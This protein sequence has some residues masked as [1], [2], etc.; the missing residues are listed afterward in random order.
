M[1]RFFSAVVALLLAVPVAAQEPTVQ[2]ETRGTS[3]TITQNG[4]AVTLT[5]TGGLASLLIQTSGTFDTTWELQCAAD[6]AGTAFDADDEIPVTLVAASPTPAD[7]VTN[8]AEALYTANIAG[9][10]AVRVIATAYSSGT[11]TVTLQAITSGGGSGGGGGGGG[12]AVTGTGSAGTPATGVLTVQGITSGTAVNVS[13]SAGCSSSA[14][15]VVSSSNNSTSNLAG[16]AAFTGTGEEVT[17][18]AQIQVSV[19][20]SHASAANGLSVQQSSDNSNWDI[21]DTFTVSA[22]TAMV[23]SVPAQARYFRVVYTNGATLT[24]SLRIQTIFKAAGAKGS[25]QRPADAMTNE[26][27]FEQGLSYNMGFNGT[28]WD[29]LRTVNTGYL[30]V[31]PHYAGTAASTGTGASGAQTQRVVTATDSTIGTVTSV[32]NVATIGTSVTP[33]NAAA[34]LGKAEDAVAAS[35]DTGVQLLGVRADTA[36]AT[37]ANGDYVPILMDSIGRQWITGADVE[38]AA[39]TAGGSLLMIGCVRQDTAAS[40]SGTSGDNSNCTTDADGRIYANVFGVT[41]A[42]ATYLTVRLS[43]GSNFLTPSTDSTHDSA[44]GTTGPA[45]MG[46]ATTAM[47][48]DTAVADGDATRLKAD[49]NGRQLSLASCPRQDRVRGQATITDGSSTSVLAALGANIIAEIYEIEIANSSAS[50]VTVDMR[51]GTGGSVLWTLIAPATGGNNRT[52]TVPLTFT[53][54][55]AV[56]ADPSASASSIIVSVLGCRVL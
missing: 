45:I 20:S 34:N 24:T 16:G 4:G 44:V 52:F 56:A 35:G 54:N 40:S 2:L 12:G 26:N 41:Q 22:T 19:F 6:A 49:T 5:N 43:D 53:A 47:T 28:T 37:A 32:T 42:A 3:G 8:D 31:T 9:C 46:E 55:T 17:G 23:I 33:G 30:G 18:Y 27:D 1:T 39:A 50:T 7:Q 48:S 11:Q 36:A 29:R 25:S 15:G 38:D 14:G 51:D 21:T 10:T 13:C